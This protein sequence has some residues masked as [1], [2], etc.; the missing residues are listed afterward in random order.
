MW[1]LIMHKIE[2]KSVRKEQMSY[3]SGTWYM[4]SVLEERK[5][6]TLAFG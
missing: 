2:N 1:Q 6:N 5:K 4:D 3:G